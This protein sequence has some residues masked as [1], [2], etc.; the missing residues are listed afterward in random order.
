M[1][2]EYIVNTTYHHV[3]EQDARVKFWCL[4]DSL[5]TFRCRCEVH[6]EKDNYITI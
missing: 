2:W 5:R 4:E 6:L 1:R 3:R